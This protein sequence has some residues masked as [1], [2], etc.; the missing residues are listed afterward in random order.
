MRTYGRVPDGLG[1]LRWVEVSSNSP[2]TETQ[3]WLTTLIQNLKLIVGESPFW[4]DWGIP[5]EQSV[6]KQIMPDFNVNL[7]Q[8]RFAQYFANLSIVRTPSA[9]PTPTY[10]V[11]VLTRYGS[12]IETDIPT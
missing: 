1:N 2:E 4:A 3:V 11:N 6:I 10:R 7:T 9:R 8:Q 5:A 12:L